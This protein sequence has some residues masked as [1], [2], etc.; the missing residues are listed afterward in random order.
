MAG[1]FGLPE[2]AT[3]RASPVFIIDPATG[4]VPGA[5]AGS[6]AALRVG[7]VN[8]GG[9]SQLPL[10]GDIFRV[11]AQQSALSDA[12]ISAIASQWSRELGGTG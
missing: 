1:R 12:E 6:I 2:N 7:S 4:E 11:Y 5:T 10:D 9:T 8:S 3:E